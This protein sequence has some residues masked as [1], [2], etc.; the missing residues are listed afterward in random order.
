MKQHRQK[1]NQLATFTTQYTRETMKK[2][3]ATKALVIVAGLGMFAGTAAAEPTLQDILNNIT[4]GGQSSLNATT[5][6]I[7]DGADAYWNITGSGNSSATMI[8]EIS[9]VANSNTFGIFDS[10]NP[11]NRVQLFAGSATTGKRATV[12]IWD[13]GGVYLN[14]ADDPIATF[15]GSSFGYYIGANN[16]FFYSDSSLNPDGADYMLAY[17]GNDRDTIKIGN[18][19]PGIWTNNEYILAFEDWNDFDFN[20]MLVMVESVQPVPEPA[21]LLLVGAGVAGLAVL[22]R[23]R[24]TSVA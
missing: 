19:R 17:Q 10:A 2:H 15:R 18:M 1:N 22:S 23:R 13:N 20:D 7:Q 21:S 6:M 12:S 4:V 5:D 8:I 24:K 9:G 11:Q 14:N 16:T 3:I